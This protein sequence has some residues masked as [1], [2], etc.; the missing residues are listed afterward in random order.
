MRERHPC[1]PQEARLFLHPSHD[2]SGHPAASGR[3]GGL[4]RPHTEATTSRSSCSW[5]PC[6]PQLSSAQGES[7]PCPP[8]HTHQPHACPPP[9]SLPSAH[10]RT[11]PR[12]EPLA[13]VPPTLHQNLADQHPTQSRVGTH[14]LPS[15]ETG[16]VPRRRQTP[17]NKANTSF[18]K[19]HRGTA[20]LP[21]R[22]P[23]GSRL[24]WGQTCGAGSGRS[25]APAV[26]ISTWG[27]PTPPRPPCQ[28][29]PTPPHSSGLLLGEKLWL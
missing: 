15:G 14:V 1:R 22:R 26:E 23:Q 25:G 7:S 17:R 2:L 6:L 9:H 29:A 16:G 21:P 27:W 19:T 4:Q 11:R 18:S 8:A 20:D 13:A 3:R 28:A 12:K 5:G 24:V 10:T